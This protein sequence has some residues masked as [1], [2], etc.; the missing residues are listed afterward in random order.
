[1]D[2]IFNKIVISFANNENLIFT[3]EEFIEYDKFID[4]EI[5]AMNL[6]KCDEYNFRGVKFADKINEKLSSKIVALYPHDSRIDMRCKGQAA[7]FLVNNE[8]AILTFSTNAI[9][10]L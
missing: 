8:I 2:N 7:Y 5:S 9:N 1:M 4:D 10:F 3:D 6:I